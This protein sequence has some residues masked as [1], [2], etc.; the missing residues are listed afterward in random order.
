MTAS[1]LDSL[2]NPD[3]HLTD[4]YWPES[5]P[6]RTSQRNP[7]GA[8]ASCAEDFAKHW[9]ET[10]GTLGVKDREIRVRMGKL[11]FYR[12]FRHS[13]ATSVLSSLYVEKKGVSL[14]PQVG[15][16]PTT[17]RLTAEWLIGTSRGKHET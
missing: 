3:S 17:L 9:G 10:G 2:P 5:P 6:P 1:C 14:A 13:A 4:L 7:T 8:P 16:E 15:F 11:K 12:Q